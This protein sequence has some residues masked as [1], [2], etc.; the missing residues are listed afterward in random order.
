METVEKIYFYK[1]TTDN[2]GAP[3]SYNSILTLA[4]CKPKIRA[5]AQGNDWIVGFGGKDLDERLIYVAQVKE[6]LLNGEY[7]KNE[8]YY[9]RPDCIYRWDARTQKYYWVNG[10]KYHTDGLNLDHD[11]DNGKALVLLSEKYTYL[12][13]QG[14]PKYKA[15][16]LELGKYIESLKQGHRVN[17]P[18]TLFNELRELIQE[19]I[20]LKIDGKPSDPD[21]CKACN[22]IEG[23]IIVSSRKFTKCV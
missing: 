9:E 6:K 17:H 5:T 8:K 7:Y 16:Y 23:E 13:N 3:C 22:N 19:S 15:K 2:G 18:E 21:R 1:M 12:G 14:T 11:L 20:D 4:I 10:K